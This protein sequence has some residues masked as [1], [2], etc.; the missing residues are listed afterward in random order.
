MSEEENNN[1]GRCNNRANN[2]QDLVKFNHY[3]AELDFDDNSESVSLSFDN[4]N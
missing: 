1:S 3:A 2:D 4:R